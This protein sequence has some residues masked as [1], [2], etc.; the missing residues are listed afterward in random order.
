MYRIILLVCIMVMTACG[1]QSNKTA[2]VEA[3]A[4]G[5]FAVKFAKDGSATFKGHLH[6]LSDLQTVLP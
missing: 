3:L 4:N 2:H 5:E 6:N 1:G